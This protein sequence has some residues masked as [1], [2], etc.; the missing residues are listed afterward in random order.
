MEHGAARFNFIENLTILSY[1]TPLLQVIAMLVRLVSWKSNSKYK[2]LMK[3]VVRDQSQIQESRRFHSFLKNINGSTDPEHINLLHEALHL[4]LSSLLRPKDLDNEA[5]ISCP[6]EQI[7]FL[8]SLTKDG[9]KTAA[10]VKS[11]CCRMQFGFRI[12]Y[13]HLIRMAATQEPNARF[14]LYLKNHTGDNI[15]SK[16]MILPLKFV[17]T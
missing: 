13:V 6:T 14:S 12:I 4:L 3:L 7:I 1:R 17:E 2:N 8:A 16:Q 15:L 5:N 10:S 9:F 11:L